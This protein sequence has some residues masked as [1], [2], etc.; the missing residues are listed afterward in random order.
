M[1]CITAVVNGRRS[2]TWMFQ[3]GVSSGS[4]VYRSP[5]VLLGCSDWFN[6]LR[7]MDEVPDGKKLALHGTIR[8]FPGEL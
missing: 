3:L 2:C 4:I 1:C 8:K 5:D 7:N 6:A